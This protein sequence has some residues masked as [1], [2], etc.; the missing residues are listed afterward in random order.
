LTHLLLRD[1]NARPVSQVAHADHEAGGAQDHNSSGEQE[2]EQENEMAQPEMAQQKQ[3]SGSIDA[4]DLPCHIGPQIS[5]GV[6][7]TMSDEDTSGSISVGVQTR[8]KTSKVNPSQIETASITGDP[9]SSK[10]LA[11]SRSKPGSRRTPTV[12]KDTK[13]SK[14]QKFTSDSSLVRQE[15]DAFITGE[16]DDGNGREGNNDC[17]VHEDSPEDAEA[18]LILKG[19]DLLGNMWNKTCRAGLG[20]VPRVINFTVSILRARVDQKVQDHNPTWQGKATSHLDDQLRRLPRSARALQDLKQELVIPDAGEQLFMLRKRVALARFYDV[21]TNAQANPHTFLSRGRD[22][23]LLVETLTATGKRKRKSSSGVS[24]G[25]RDRL[26]TLVQNRIIDVM[27]PDTLIEDANVDSEE[28]TA[29]RAERAVK[30]KAA[31]QKLQ[32]WRA[33]GKPLSALINRFGWESCYCCP[34]TCPTRSKRN[35]TAVDNFPS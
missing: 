35:R 12:P 7:N 22:E 23:V 11:K 16:A 34:R 29:D 9:S 20:E 4:S 21:Y 27:F 6:N 30:R 24:A 28:E 8:S 31:G 3:I 33:N 10:T 1:S 13:R 5:G 26:S 2:I 15:H 14:I 25:R 19:P 32:N 18:G 17:D